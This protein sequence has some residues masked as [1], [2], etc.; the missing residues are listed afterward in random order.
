MPITEREKSNEVS[1]EAASEVEQ[2]TRGKK[3]LSSLVL[4]IEP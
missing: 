4:F 1:S 2:A 3:A